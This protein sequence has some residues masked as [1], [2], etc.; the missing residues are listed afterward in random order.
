[1]TFFELLLLLLIA[2]VC[3]SIGQAIAG[4]SRGGCVISIVVGFIGALLGTWMSNQLGL[5]ELFD[6]PIGG[7]TFPIIWSIIGSVVFVV[8]V[9]LFTKK[10]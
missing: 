3:G 6:V 7:N 1:M 10:R 4:Y 8:I 2:G 9:G 5:P